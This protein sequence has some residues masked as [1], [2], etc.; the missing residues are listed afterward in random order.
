MLRLNP[1]L[2]PR[3]NGFVN[4]GATCYLNSALQCLLTCTSLFEVLQKQKSHVSFQSSP[5]AKSL[6][7]LYERSLSGA[8]I[9]QDC[10]AVWKCLLQFASARDERVRLTSGQQD[11]PE[12]ITLIFDALSHIPDVERLFTYRHRVRIFCRD[13]ESWVSERESEYYIFE[14]QANLKT[15]QA[16]CNAALD[17]NYNRSLPLNEFLMRQNTFI[18]ADYKCPKCEVQSVKYKVTD[19]V[20][21]PEILPIMLKKY[22]KKEVVLYPEELRFPTRTANGRSAELIYK[23]IARSE[24]SGGRGGGHYWADCIRASSSR[25]PTINWTCLNDMS[26]SNSSAPLPSINTYLLMY[27]FVGVRPK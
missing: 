16:S 23:L 21:V 4:L 9:S 19:I 13:C 15:E 10:I 5:I 7:I 24:H 17:V 12:C 11:A 14:V 3:P 25:A 27:H 26:V 20:M 6:L 18:D 2:I 8:D 1:A 22:E